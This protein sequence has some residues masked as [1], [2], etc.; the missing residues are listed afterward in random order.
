M[1][2][3][4]ITD[5]VREGRDL[6]LTPP[7]DYLYGLDC[8]LSR[9]KGKVRAELAAPHNPRSTGWKSQNHHINGHCQQIAVETGASFEAV[10]Y[11]MKMEAIGA[12][13]LIDT[14]PNGQAVPKSEG[15]PDISSWHASI[16]I[17]TIHRI[18]AEWSIFLREE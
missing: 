14:L 4:P 11:F 10:K 9:L 6:I 5:Y 7:R 16:L 12:G 3:L 18:A 15:D 13:W 2:R 1:L 8:F 17:E